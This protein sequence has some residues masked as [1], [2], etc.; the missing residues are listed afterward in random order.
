MRTTTT[1]T[2]NDLV[3]PHSFSLQNVQD[4]CVDTLFFRMLA[5]PWQFPGVRKS[6]VLTMLSVIALS[7]LPAATINAADQLDDTE[8][9]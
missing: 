7:P 4:R 5:Y 8:Y 2:R 9:R 3:R 1:A 6:R